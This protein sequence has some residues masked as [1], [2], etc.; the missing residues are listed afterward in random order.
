MEGW[1]ESQDSINVYGILT[2][3]NV[4]ERILQVDILDERDRELVMRKVSTAAASWNIS[5]Q[6][7]VKYQ[8]A[9]QQQGREFKSVAD[10]TASSLLGPGSVAAEEAP[11]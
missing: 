3:E 8:Y 9:S 7:T 2:L 4:I 1:D 5:R 6:P 10:R 11:V